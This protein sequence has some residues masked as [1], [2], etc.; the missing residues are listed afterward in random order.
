MVPYI[1]ISLDI[2]VNIVAIR[3]VSNPIIL[4]S[5]TYKSIA[6]TTKL[7]AGCL[8]NSVVFT[9]GE[10]GASIVECMYSSTDRAQH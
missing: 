4:L 10:L 9:S 2:I 6:D 5:N 8:L 7:T 1:Y 3:Y